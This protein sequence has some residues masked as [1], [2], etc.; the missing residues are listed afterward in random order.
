MCLSRQYLGTLLLRS[1]AGMKNRTS[2]TA[3]T[4]NRALIISRMGPKIAPSMD[5]GGPPVLSPPAGVEEGT[6]GVVAGTTVPVGRLVAVGVGEVAGVGLVV[7]VGEASVM[8]IWACARRAPVDT[9]AALTVTSG[10]S[11]LAGR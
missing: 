7:G 3:E 10:W 5:D 4:P 9:S 2:I 1:S 6:V 8:R 11:R